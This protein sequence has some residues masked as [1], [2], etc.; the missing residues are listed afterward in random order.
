MMYIFGTIMSPAKEYWSTVTVIVLAFL[1][2]ATII[3]YFIKFTVLKSLGVRGPTPFP[4]FGHLLEIIWNNRVLHE[5]ERDAQRAYGRV[6]GIYMFNTP[7]IVTSDPEML[8]EIFVKSFNNFHDRLVCMLYF[9]NS[10][11]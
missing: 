6:Y 2:L 9:S 8:K 11:I 3:H 7:I 10:N 1:F 4:I 5:R